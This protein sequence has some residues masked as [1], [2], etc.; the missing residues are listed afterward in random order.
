MFKFEFYIIRRRNTFLWMTILYIHPKNPPVKS[1]G[2]NEGA[3]NN[4]RKITQNKCVF[5]TLH[6]NLAV[7]SRRKE[8]GRKFAMRI[9]GNRI[10]HDKYT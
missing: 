8:I 9:P 6:E 7:E 10:Y 2:T 4:L 5:Y 1:C 3:R